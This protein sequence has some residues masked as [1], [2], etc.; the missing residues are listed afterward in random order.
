MK[1]Q[2]A[3]SGTGSQQREIIENNFLV[4]GKT[5]VKMIVVWI[6]NLNFELLPRKINSCKFISRS[7]WR[8][9]F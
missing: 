8:I 7:M 3:G 6:I 2:K 9:C 1:H 5:Y 4:D